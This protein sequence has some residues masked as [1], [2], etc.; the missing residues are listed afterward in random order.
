MN[1]R[2]TL[3]KAGGATAPVA[4]AFVALAAVEVSY[5]PGRDSALHVEALRDKAVA[6]AELT[7]HSV[8]PALEFEDEAVL[9]EFLSGVARDPDVAYVAACSGDGK[10]IRALDDGKKSARCRA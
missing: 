6:L 10:M 5:F 1:L 9:V 7:A 4:F 3:A 2:A 8:A